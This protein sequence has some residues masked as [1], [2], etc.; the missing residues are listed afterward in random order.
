LKT[1]DEFY[2]PEELKVSM[3]SL[4]RLVKD[5]RTTFYAQVEDIKTHG[6]FNKRTFANNL[7]LLKVFS[8]PLN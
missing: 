6:R 3:G 2:R 5:D 4:N 1:A 8:M 7:A